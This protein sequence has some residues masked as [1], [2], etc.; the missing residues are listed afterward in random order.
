MSVW[1]ILKYC[2]TSLRYLILP[3]AAP[4]LVI[5]VGLGQMAL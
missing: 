1:L 2:K 5:L 3:P 4:L